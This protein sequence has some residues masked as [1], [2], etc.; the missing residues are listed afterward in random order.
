MPGISRSGVPRKAFYLTGRVGDTDLALH[1]E[2]SRVIL[3]RSDGGR[4]E[5]DL[6]ATG[7]RGEEPG[8][9]EVP[10]PIAVTATIAAAS[11]ASEGGEA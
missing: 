7:R 9:T 4:D 11:E 10:E 2:G 1:S 6:E 5:V 8:P 3:T